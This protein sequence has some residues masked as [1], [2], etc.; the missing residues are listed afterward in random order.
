MRAPYSRTFFDLVCEQ[1]E[2]YPHAAAVICEDAATTYAALRNAAA[3]IAT[4]LRAIGVGQGE[5]VGLLLNN[6]TQW[7]EICFGVAALGAVAVPFSTW[8]KRR[9]LDFLIKDSGIKVLFT[10]DRLGNQ[11]YAKDL[12]ELIP[13]IATTVAWQSERYPLLQTV[14]ML[15]D[16]PLAGAIAYD[17]FGAD[18]A[19][20][21][22]PLAPGYGP[23]A[24]DPALVLYTSGSTS[25]P[26]AVPLTHAASIENGFNIGERQGLRPGDRVL[27]SPPLFWSY[28]SANAMCATM[29]HGATLVLQGRFEPGEALD[30]IERHR[31]TAI[32]TLPGMTNAM[33]LHESFT[34]ERTR[35]LRTGLTIGTPHDIEAAALTLGA[36]EICNVYGQT[37]SYGNCSVTWHHWPLQ[38]RMQV[39]GPPLPGVRIRIVDEASGAPVAAGVAGLIEVK[40]NITPGY[41]GVSAQNNAAA[42]SAD[43]YF[44]TGDLGRLTP[45]GNVQFVGRA[46]EIIKRSGINIAP[47]EVEEV[48]RH[49][50]GVAQ[51]GVVGVADADKGEIVMAFVVPEPGAEL[52]EDALRQFC[53]SEA[54]SYKTPDHVQLCSALPTTPTGKLMRSELKQMA[55][56]ARSQ[57]N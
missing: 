4:G 1:A 57:A 19:P 36:R 8:S 49:C 41:E 25:Y 48:L 20:I 11:D 7:L 15:G 47:A 6:C 28:G 17:A 3:R 40:G 54:A 37:E 32:Y 51:A 55:I 22:L 12:A 45:E 44:R 9:E 14:V 35:S 34:P 10:L 33:V 29:T 13:S 50:P 26:K 21:E 39:Q 52:S 2:R 27:L 56:K 30:L 43:G 16:S 53:R 24:H 42:F 31:C 46:S 23:R 18:R 38:R 5:R